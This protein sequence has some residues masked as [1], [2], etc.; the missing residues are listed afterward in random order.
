M[1]RRNPT[2]ADREELDPR[3]D[4]DWE[5]RAA[6]EGRYTVLAPGFEEAP[7]STERPL[8]PADPSPARPP[9]HRSGVVPRMAAPEAARA[10]RESFVPLPPFPALASEGDPDLDPF[11]PPA[12]RPPAES[13][14]PDAE[15]LPLRNPK[16]AIAGARF[17]RTRTRAYVHTLPF[18]KAADDAPASEGEFQGASVPA[19]DVI[20]LSAPPATDT[21]RAFPVRMVEHA[22]APE[23]RLPQVEAAPVASRSSSR[24][25][26]IAVVVVVA[27]AALVAALE[28]CAGR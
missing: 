5:P 11:V 8:A 10:E 3:H 19:P 7:Y 25:L 27:A 1:K 23:P 24:L 28:I 21:P 26:S 14:S 15:P 16:S 6:S 18:L 2:S 13:S 17:A 9:P 4:G 12:P 20:D 22:A